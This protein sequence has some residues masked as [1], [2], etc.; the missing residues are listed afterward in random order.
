MNNIDITCSFCG[1][2]HDEVNKIIAGPGV[3][4]CDECI[5]ICSEIMEEE[6]NMYD[7]EADYETGINLLKPEEIKAFLDDYVLSLIHI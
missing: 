2:S 1:K 6:F 7:H 5:G 4:I 3:Y